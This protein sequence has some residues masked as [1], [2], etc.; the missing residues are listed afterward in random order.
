MS[1][2]R[3][4]PRAQ[5]LSA[6]RERHLAERSSCTAGV[7]QRGGEVDSAGAG[8]RERLLRCGIHQRGEIALSFD[9]RFPD[10]AA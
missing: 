5:H 2:Q 3:L 4:G 7:L 1:V 6:L 8:A 9:P 10:V